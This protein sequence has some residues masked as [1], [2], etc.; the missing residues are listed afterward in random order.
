MQDRPLV[1]GLK[2]T[3]YVCNGEGYVELSNVIKAPIISRIDTDADS[4]LRDTIGKLDEVI[5][6]G[7]D[8]NGNEFYASNVA[9]GT[10]ALWHL[11]RA[12]Y[13]LLGVVDNIDE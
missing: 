9:D 10:N 13:N 1:W 7:Y 2:D 12:T 8:K 4:V 5:I 3:C 11:Q 6:V